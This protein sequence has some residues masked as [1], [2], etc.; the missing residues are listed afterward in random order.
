MRYMV[1]EHFT[2]GARAIY[3]RAAERGRMLPE[4]LRYIDSWIDAEDLERCFQL[5]ETDDPALFDE[6][7]SNWSDLGEIEVVPVINSA[8]AAGRALA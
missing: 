7:F 4:G 5:M 2:Q 3:E 1:I 8:E 6:W